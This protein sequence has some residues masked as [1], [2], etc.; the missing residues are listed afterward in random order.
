MPSR[1]PR[2]K[3]SS[4]SARQRRDPNE[5]LEEA[6]ASDTWRPPRPYVVVCATEVADPFASERAIHALLAARRVNTRHEF[7][8]IT[9]LEARVLLSL[10]AAV[11]PAQNEQSEAEPP[12]VLPAAPSQIAPDEPGPAQIRTWTPEGKLRA[13]VEQHYLHVPLREKDTGTKLEALYAAYWSSVPPVHSKLLGR[14]KF[15]A[16]LSAVYP[17]IGPHRN[18]ESTI[19][20]PLPTP[21]NSA[22]S[23]GPSGREGLREDFLV[24][25]GALVLR[26]SSHTLVGLVFAQKA[27]RAV[28]GRPCTRPSQLWK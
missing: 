21:L 5:R 24:H 9:A 26:R 11:T 3:A 13:W 25:E 28:D 2:C 19:K 22:D 14:N 6:N 16:M 7:F 10:L 23:E 20:R 1:L 4:R 18:K 27:E 8:E 15:A 12:L 17:N